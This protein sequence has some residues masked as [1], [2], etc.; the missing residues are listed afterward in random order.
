MIIKDI[1]KR[2]SQGNTYTDTS[3]YRSSPWRKL[4][5]Q[6]LKNDPK[7]VKCGKLGTMIDHIKRIEEGGE[8]LDM[9]NLQTMCDHCHNVKRA[10]EKNAKYS[11]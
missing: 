1:R 7:C 9:S 3:F 10:Q 6:K 2:K 4:R 8:K 5:A 11:K